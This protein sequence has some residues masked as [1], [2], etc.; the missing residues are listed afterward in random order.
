MAIRFLSQDF[1]CDSY[2][3]Y[4]SELCIYAHILMR[5]D[6]CNTNMY[7]HLYGVFV[8]N[9]PYSHLLS[10]SLSLSLSHSLTHFFA[11]HL[12]CVC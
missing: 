7:F 5:I 6:A 2:I 1:S 9:L 10:L 11:L 4:T 12:H 8:T 3:S